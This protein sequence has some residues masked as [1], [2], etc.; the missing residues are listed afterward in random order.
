MT[1]KTELLGTARLM[2]ADSIGGMRMPRVAFEGE[3]AAAG[4]GQGEGAAAAGGEAASGGST[5]DTGGS[6]GGATGGAAGD[7]GATKW[8][9]A[10]TD[11]EARKFAETSTDLNAF[12]KR[13]MDLRTKLSTAI[14]KPG[15]DAKPEEVAAYRKAMDIPETIEGYDFAR[16]E[17][18]DEETFGSEGMKATL[19]GVA[20]VLH[21]AGVSKTQAQ[22][23]WGWYNQ[24][25][26]QA[27]QAQ[28]AA[29]KQFA[30][31]TDA[32]LKQKWGGDY[33]KNREFAKRGFEKLATDAGLDVEGLKKIETKDGRFLLDRPEFSELFAKIGREM[34]EGQIGSVLSDGE[35]KSIQDQ[36]DKL[37][38]DKREALA[39]GD[40][41]KAQ[42][43]DDKQRELYGKLPQKAA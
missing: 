23:I 5:G 21:E 14:V 12:V 11:P 22:A 29:D 41:T 36:I 24:M 16:P 40:H 26:A 39:R 30:T 38:S 1:V 7:T 25:E 6:A 15:K 9:E 34:G 17:H 10:I 42:S 20:G 19:K 32:A 35:A 2:F 27:V 8:R 33:D 18:V 43:L 13:T 31:Q 3:G 37:Q 28:I 4:G